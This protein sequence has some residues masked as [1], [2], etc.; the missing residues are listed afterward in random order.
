MLASRSLL[1][2][3]LLK[4]FDAYIAFTAF[5]QSFHLL[6]KVFKLAASS[7]FTAFWQS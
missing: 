5:W 1:S 2:G 3:E 7:P 4:V 6:E